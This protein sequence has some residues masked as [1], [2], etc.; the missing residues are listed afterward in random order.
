LKALPRSDWPL[1]AI[2][3]GCLVALSLLVAELGLYSRN[4]PEQ[5]PEWVVGKSLPAVAV[6]GGRRVSTTRQLLAGNQL[7]LEAWYGH[8]EILLGRLLRLGELRFDFRLEPKAYL[9]LIFGKDGSGWSGF[10][11]SRDP[12]RPSI[13]YR[14]DRRGRFVETAP[15]DAVVLGDSTHSA[16]LRC[17]EGACELHLDGQPVGRA[18]LAGDAE[19]AVSFLGG[20]H[21]VDVDRVQVWDRD[22][23]QIVDERFRNDRHFWRLTAWSF[24]ASGLVL[25]GVLLLAV[26]L[27]RQWRPSLMAASLL[28][29]TSVVVLGGVLV[30]DLL[31]WSERY[32]YGTNAAWGTDYTVNPAERLRKHLSAL[33]AP[34]DTVSGDEA[35]RARFHRALASEE[36]HPGDELLLHVSRDPAGP[37][38]FVGDSEEGIRAYLSERPRPARL[39]LFLGTSQMWGSGAWRQTDRLL[40][41]VHRRLAMTPGLGDLW[42]VNGSRQGSQSRKLLQRYRGHLALFE[43]DLVVVDL[44]NNDT[45]PR[46]FRANLR[47]LAKLNRER[48]VATLFVQEPNSVEWPSELSRRHAVMAEVG[49]RA[50]IP[51]VDLHGYL[52]GP[53]VVDSGILFHDRVHLTSYGQERAGGFI[54]RAMVR[55]FRSELTAP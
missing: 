16:A 8:N 6:M 3:L 30:F 38:E 32:Q 37:L 18:P 13:R 22:G 7:N 42:L 48:G 15:L 26:R 20:R 53:R 29:A 34:L 50:G 36:P 35:E 40:V 28:L 5:H 1:V 52:A 11:L 19:R 47:R 41:Q 45:D 51:V 14:A 4:T 17:E 21:P 33:I 31:Y 27:G 46:V 9:H 44:S 54:A 55:H 43:P 23:V 49:E 24:V 2:L 10:R 12:S 39:V 25:A